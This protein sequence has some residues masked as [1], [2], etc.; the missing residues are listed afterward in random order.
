MAKSLHYQIALR[1]RALIADPKHWTQF[2][3]ARYRNGHEVEPES[4]RAY[5][6]CAV[7]AIMRAAHELCADAYVPHDELVEKV[8][9]LIEPQLMEYNDLGR[10]KTMR[11]LP[12]SRCSMNISPP[13]EWAYLGRYSCAEG[14]RLRFGLRLS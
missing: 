11:T 13:A 10:Q 14:F 7:G 1:A 4:P 2:A 8:A 12:F 6:F 9:T 3:L 5:R